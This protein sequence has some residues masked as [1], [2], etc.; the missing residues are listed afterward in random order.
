MKTNWR[1][2]FKIGATFNIKKKDIEVPE[3]ERYKTPN[4]N[5]LP[6]NAKFTGDKPPSTGD[7]Y[8]K[9]L[10]TWKTQNKE[11]EKAKKKEGKSP[12]GSSVLNEDRYESVEEKVK[13]KNVT[14]A[15]MGGYIKRSW[16]EIFAD[17]TVKKKPD[18]TIEMN[19]DESNFSQ[20]TSLQQPID[21]SLQQPQVPPQTQPVQEEVKEASV[22]IKERE[23]K[24]V[25]NFSLIAKECNTHAAIGIYKGKEEVEFH[26]IAKNGHQWNEVISQG[27]WETK[28]DEIVENAK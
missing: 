7:S 10:S 1:E 21:P 3:L 28:F 19:I 5:E 26:K 6:N 24:K 4:K 15:I 9:E 2:F 13:D 20:D 23:I 27:L 8:K 16:K 17:M 22:K 11:Y 12:Q 25:G 18:G 14:P